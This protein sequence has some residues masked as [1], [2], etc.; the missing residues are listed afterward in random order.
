MSDLNHS[1]D[2]YMKIIKSKESIDY[3]RKIME[4][5][6]VIKVAHNPIKGTRFM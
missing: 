3:L 1:E 4:K 5:K 6:G 2:L